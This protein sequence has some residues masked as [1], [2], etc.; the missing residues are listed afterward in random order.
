MRPIRF[1]AWDTEIKKMREV[2]S[3][4][5]GDPE[6][7]GATIETWGKIYTDHETGEHEAD[8][9][10]IGIHR[11]ILMQFTGLHDKNGKEIWE[12]DVIKLSRYWADHFGMETTEIFFEKGAFRFAHNRV[13]EYEVGIVGEESEV[14]GNI[15]ESP[16]ETRL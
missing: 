13:I 3:I 6:F 12:G 16:K 2:L 5:F 9:D 8:R 11:I 14:I 4:N 7:Q 10:I 15:Y 1:R